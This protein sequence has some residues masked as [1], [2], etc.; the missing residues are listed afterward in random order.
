[1]SRK[2]YSEEER[3]L[4]RSRLMD[5]AA[6][7]FKEKGIRETN[8]DEIYTPVGISKTFFYSFFPSK[9]VLAIAIMKEGMGGI[10][11]LFRRNVWEYGAENGIRETFS[12]VSSG[13]FYIPG[14]DDQVYIR[15][16]LSEQEL[17]GFQNDLVVLFSDMLYTVGVPASKLDPRVVCNMTMSVLTTRMTEGRRMLLTFAETADNTS[18]LQIKSLVALILENRVI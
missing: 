2:A 18:S 11:D 12:D 14:E 5:V 15:E 16:H 13:R 3:D 8:I 10:G 6:A 9:A 4:I 7:L 1:M 17:I